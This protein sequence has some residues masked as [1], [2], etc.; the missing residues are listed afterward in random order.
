MH[1]APALLGGVLVVG[2]LVYMLSGDGT[3]TVSQLGAGYGRQWW[4]AIAA[5]GVAT[6]VLRGVGY[7]LLRAVRRSG[8]VKHRTLIVGAGLVGAEIAEVLLTYPEYGLLPVAFHDPEPLRSV[9]RELPVY[10]TTSLGQSIRLSGATIVVVGYSTL[11]DS[12]LVEYLQQYHRERAE[13]FLVP[14]LYELDLGTPAEVEHIR[15]LSLRRLRRAAHR[16][17][18]WDIKLV[19]DRVIAALALIV[20]SPLM[21]AIAI[22]IRLTMG[23]PVIFRQERVGIDGA[24]F[25]I[26]KFRTLPTAPTETADTE[27]AAETT[28]RPTPVGDLLRNT[29]LDELPQLANILKG[30]M[31]FVGPRPE[32]PHFV[33]EFANRD[34]RYNYRHR[35]PCGLTGLSQ[36]SGL[37]GDTSISERARFDNTYVESWSLMGD[38]KIIMRTLREVF[39][40]ARK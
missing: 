5:A 20:L 28:R 17:V 32:R 10:T 19:L 21:L 1:D 4:A 13:F 23:S 38:F 40:R 33:G 30:E 29:S 15:S 9:N 39:P 6:V 36:V 24:R 2:S 12:Q 16:T 34:R 8:M 27:W 35:V 7:W 22:A 3:A 11:P 37:R 26:L 14:R 25:Q 31:S 18:A